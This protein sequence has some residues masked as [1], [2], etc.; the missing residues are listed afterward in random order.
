MQFQGATGQLTVFLGNKGD[1]PLQRMVCS[2]PPSAQFSFQQGAVPTVLEPKKQ[3]QVCLR[4]R[5]DWP[6]S[7]AGPPA[8][9]QDAPG[10]QAVCL[11]R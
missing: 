9:T 4:A 7:S 1:E 10:T 5:L 6:T 2:V 11:N 3:I 8:C